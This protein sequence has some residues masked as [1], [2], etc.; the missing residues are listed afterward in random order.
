MRRLILSLPVTVA[1]YVANAHYLSQDKIE[2]PQI[3]AGEYKL[4]VAIDRCE[5]GTLARGG[6]LVLVAPAVN[7]QQGRESTAASLSLP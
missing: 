1:A 7:A 5:S 6:R 2:F 3:E 4:C